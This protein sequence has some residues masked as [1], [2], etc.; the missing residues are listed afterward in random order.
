MGVHFGA[1]KSGYRSQKQLVLC[2]GY[3]LIPTET[4]I[5]TKSDPEINDSPSKVGLKLNLM[6]SES[7][8]LEFYH[9]SSKASLV[10]IPKSSVKGFASSS[11]YCKTSAPLS[12][13]KIAYFCL[14]RYAIC[15]FLEVLRSQPV[16]NMRFSTLFNIWRFV[17]L[18]NHFVTITD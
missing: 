1:P 11:G 18:Q 8:V 13:W 2:P 4:T 17:I 9:P 16:W 3:I 15:T 10:L 6:H 14:F 7:E 12:K 5:E